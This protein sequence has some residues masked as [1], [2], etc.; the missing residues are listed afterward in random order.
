MPHA[1]RL[2][3]FVFCAT[4]II[5]APG[6]AQQPGN[7]A[8]EDALR[9]LQAAQGGDV[10]ISSHKSTGAARFIRVRP[11]RALSG[12][13][14][15]A[16]DKE[17]QSRAFFREY[18]PAAGISDAFALRLASSSIDALGDTHLTW[19][20]FYGAVPVFAGTIKTHFDRSHRLKAVT[21]TAIPD[22]AVD[23]TP[24]WASDRAAPVARAAVVAERGD[25]DALRIGTTTLY[26]YPRGPR[27]GHSRCESPGL[28]N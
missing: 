13:A 18:G 16:R 26:V 20:Q 6:L 11:G 28:G 25:S 5:S 24:T 23:A 3:T 1:S 7:Q 21:G 12:P 22:I 4:F 27:P 17:Q 10:Q 2:A 8:R 9:R 14:P 19:R 15:T